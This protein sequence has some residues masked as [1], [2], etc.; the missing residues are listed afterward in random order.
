M[1]RVLLLIPAVLLCGMMPGC[2]L[3]P[4][5]VEPPYPSDVTGWRR[6]YEQGYPSLGKFVLRKGEATDNGQV[7]IKLLDLTPEEPCSGTGTWAGHRRATFQFIRASDQKVICTD[8]FPAISH[9]YIADGP[10]P[11]LFEYDIMGITI[12]AIN[13]KEG[14]VSFG[15]DGYQ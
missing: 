12:R 9:S 1:I 4:Q 8:S 10:C 11:S 15:L 5:R 14:W 13:I 6:N 3:A 7:Q 2:C